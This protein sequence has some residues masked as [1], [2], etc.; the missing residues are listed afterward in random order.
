MSQCVTNMTGQKHSNL[1]WKAEISAQFF[2]SPS[3]G[4]GFRELWAGVGLPENNNGEKK[5]NEIFRKRMHI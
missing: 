2:P 5:Q 4:N 3:E 1:L